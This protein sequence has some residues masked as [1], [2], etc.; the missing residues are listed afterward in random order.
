MQDRVTLAVQLR[1]AAAMVLAVE[2]GQSLTAALPSVPGALR[3]G[4]QALSFH[5]LRHW[6]MARALARQLA[7]REP[8]P[9]VRAL[10]GLA[11]TLLL[12]AQEDRGAH[13]SYP[14]HT[15]VDQTIEASRLW[16]PAHRSGHFLN[17]CLRN[18]LRQPHTL[19]EATPSDA[20]ARYN[21][22]FWWI[23]Q[24]RRDHPLHW[25]ALLQSNQRPAAMTLRVNRRQ[26][27]RPDFLA[28]LRAAGL[29][30][31]P[32]G[33]DGVVLQQ[34]VPV[35]QLP[36]WADGW[37]SVQDLAA[38]QAG[39]MLARPLSP[40]QAPASRVLDACA[41][42]GGKT[43]HLAERTAARILALDKDP[44][45]CQRVTENLARL[46][47]QE[48]V[49]LRCADAAAPAGWWD[50]EPFD[51]I[52]LDAPCTASGIVRRHPDVRWLRRPGDVAQLVAQ[53][54][55]L[56]DALWPLLRPG[57]WLLYATCSVFRAEGAQQTEAFLQ[58]YTDAALLP[59]PGHLLPGIPAA[60]AGMDDNLPGEHDGFFYALFS[61]QAAG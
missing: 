13:P 46:K 36:G 11:L 18:F 52:L 9:P 15:V 8:A 23:K 60:S 3:P 37:C 26:V 7:E 6:G 57:G 49:E 41:A 34:A 61:R 27:S 29:P 21:H 44:Q 53:Q 48:R 24:L 56:L 47:L 43:A 39:E 32:A 30:A 14:A 55:A 5:A 58:R 16:P 31:Q 19:L 22:P 1:W 38:Q 25:Q 28:A 45:R 54:R 20:E 10:L 35:G 51:A 59:S 40:L 4:V 12:P 42:P 17:A 2:Q 33:E 50:G